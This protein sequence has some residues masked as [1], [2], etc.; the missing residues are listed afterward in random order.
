[1]P[2]SVVP[3]I[4]SPLNV[5]EYL[6][7]PCKAISESQRMQLRRDGITFDPGITDLQHTSGECTYALN[8]VKNGFW[9][10][11]K[12]LRPPGGLNAVYQ[13]HAKGAYKD[14]W[15]PATVDGYPSVY[16]STVLTDETCGLAVAVSDADF[17]AVELS[18]YNNFTPRERGSC[19]L[20]LKV[21]SA[22]LDTV[23][24]GQ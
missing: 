7:D 13:A 18:R 14:Y 3:A 24:A 6:P 12:F 19:P 4:S 9:I 15:K 1:M 10:S 23:E 11:V 5:G 21:T 20:T 8:H 2:P 22:V 16:Y 17:I